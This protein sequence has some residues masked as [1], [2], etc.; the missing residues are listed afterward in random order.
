MS[1]SDGNENG[2]SKRE[3]ELTAIGA[4]I[5]SN[6][7]PC[8]E[9][10]IPQARK[11]G[12]SDTEIREAVELAERVRRVPA[13]KVLKSA[14]AHLEEAHGVEPNVDRME[15]DNQAA[16]EDNEMNKKGCRDETGDIAVGCGS[17]ESSAGQQRATNQTGFDFSKMMEMM[18]KC[19]P[20]N[21][22]DF[23]SKMTGFDGGCCPSKEEGS[24]KESV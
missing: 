11:A 18:Q 6:C 22:K 15:V 19:C 14:L 24:S 16:T 10:H 4:A 23:S 8:I 9:Y 20:D 13:D 17:D 1:R 2:L 21:M 5:A 12:L 3:K 7:Y